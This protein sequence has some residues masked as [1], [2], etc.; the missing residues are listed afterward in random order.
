[1]RR[2]L[3]VGTAATLAA[4]YYLRRQAQRGGA[5]GEEVRRSLPG[6]ALLPRPIL[7]TTH[8]ITIHATAE[9]IWPWLVQMGYGRG[10]WYTDGWLDR[11][12]HRFWRAMVPP[13]D[14]APYP[15]PPSAAEVRPE[16]QDLAVGDVVPDGPPGTAFYT[17]AILESPRALVLHSD[18]HGQYMTPDCLPGNTKPAS[19]GEFSWA[20]VLS[21]LDPARTRLIL[22][23]RAYSESTLVKLF[24][25]P[26]LYLGE[27]IN[28]RLMLGGIKKRVEAALMEQT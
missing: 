3:L 27:V 11:L 9:A 2:K 4:G 19:D 13:A 16:L 7:E 1:V 17:V 12:Q 21:P 28:P 5:T 10:G 20:F 6:D 23:F 18:S 15:P 22:R 24:A 8:A 14:R 26:V 25:V